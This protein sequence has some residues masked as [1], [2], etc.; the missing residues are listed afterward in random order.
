MEAATWL[1]AGLLAGL[2]DYGL[3][4]GFGLAA[5]L[6]LVV[7]LGQDPR[8]VAAAA[9]AAQLLTTLPAIAAHRR[10]GNIAPEALDDAKKVV[11]VLSA[12]STLT[13]LTAATL[14]ARLTS[15]QAHL[16]Y[17][18][19]LATLIPPLYILAHHNNRDNTKP[20]PPRKTTATAAALGALAGLDKAVLGG[21]Y[22]ILIVTAQLAAG[23]DLRSAIALT[24]AAK[25]L[26]FIAIAASYTH[27]GY[28]NPTN[29]LALAAGA[30]AS[31]PTAAKLLHRAQPEKLAPLLAA[32][33]TAS[34]ITQLLR[35]C[36]T[37][38]TP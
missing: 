6:V 4:L 28:M 1:L 30:L 33:L 32:T 23:I 16:A 38:L 37:V 5:S 9:A 25:L 17:A 21:G 8:A 13:A 19:A 14:A 7:L 15:S 35:T 3:G 27:T 36:T 2:A 10:A 34:M 24:P 11:T 20:P 22:S 18:L 29:T 26:P 12:S 31:L